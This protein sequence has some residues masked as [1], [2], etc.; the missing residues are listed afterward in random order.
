MLELDSKSI[1]IIRKTQQGNG[2]TKKLLLALQ[3]E[4]QQGNASCGVFPHKALHY[5][6]AMW[7]F[8]FTMVLQE[9]TK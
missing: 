4:P 3:K 7:C 5:K 2:V 1:G 9:S 8:N 6:V